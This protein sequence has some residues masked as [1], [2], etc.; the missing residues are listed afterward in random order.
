MHDGK[1]EAA[2]KYLGVVL[3]DGT[4]YYAVNGRFEKQGNQVQKGNQNL[5]GKTECLWNWHHHFQ[6]IQKFVSLNISLLSLT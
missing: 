3:D 4:S 5:K 1:S 6:W 2:T